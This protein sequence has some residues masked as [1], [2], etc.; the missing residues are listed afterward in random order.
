MPLI[1]SKSKKAF[2]ENVE[3][4]MKS[5][6]SQ[7]QSLAI[8]YNV[9]N[10]PKR[11]KMADGG[12]AEYDPKAVPKP[13]SSS[14]AAT[15]AAIF[16]AEGG[17]VNES[18]KS[19]RR[20]MPDERDKDS[21]MV[22]RN[23]GDKPARND[24][25]LDKSTVSQAQ[26]KDSRK[27]MPIRHPRM[28]PS[29]VFSTRMRDEEDD[30]QSSAS[31]ND[32]PQHQ[33]PMQDNEEGADR[34][35]PKISDMQ[36]EHSTHRK[37]YAKGGEVEP[38]DYST[39]PNQYEDDLL[40]L[41]PSEDEGTT[42]AESHNEED[43]DRQGPMVPDMEHEHNNGR[44]PYARGGEVSPQD[45]VEEELH[46]SIA[47]AIMARRER[48]HMAEGGAINGEDSIYTHPEADQA[49]LSRNAE[50]DANME[51]QSS[52]DALRKENYSESEGLR[53]LDSPMDSNEHGH[54]IDSDEHDM[55]SSIR[56]KMNMKRQFR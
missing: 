13:P 17:M 39:R 45:E 56:S 21:K 44:M 40:D 1:P 8:A 20:P 19:E 30:L 18:A 10:K 3:K 11:K 50:E 37:P 32:G 29:D 4:E 54:D 27:V 33:P 51:D 53:K 36:D 43:P 35:G 6:K 42:N 12:R 9:K 52:Y 49:D 16:K 41:P 2:A 24:N 7:P 55:I 15:M 28:V 48:M 31:V 47:A 34:Q 5:G 22:G 23:S 38:S 25:W 26:A 46:N 14:D